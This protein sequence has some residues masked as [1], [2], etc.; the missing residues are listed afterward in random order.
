MV[1]AVVALFILNLDECKIENPLNWSL[2]IT[3]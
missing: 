1:I 3:L 2:L